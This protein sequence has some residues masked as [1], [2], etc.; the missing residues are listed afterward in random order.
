MVISPKV[1]YFH[2]FLTFHLP[3]QA[4]IHSLSLS[5]SLLAPKVSSAPTTTPLELGFRSPDALSGS[6]TGLCCGR[7]E[8]SGLNSVL[9]VEHEDGG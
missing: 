9:A 1:D 5:Q 7:E 8:G 6:N 2:F 4:T 3:L